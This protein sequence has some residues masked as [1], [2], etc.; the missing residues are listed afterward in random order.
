VYVETWG[1]DTNPGTALAPFA[2][3]QRAINYLAPFEIANIVKIKV[4]PGTFGPFIMSGFKFKSGAQ[5]AQVLVEGTI[6]ST[7]IS[8]TATASLVDSTVLTDATKTWIADEHLGRIV[9]FDLAT[10]LFMPVY[11]NGTN[12]ISLPTNTSSGTYTYEVFNLDTIITGSVNTT[13]GTISTTADAGTGGNAASIGISGTTTGQGIAGQVALKFLSVLNT[14]NSG[15]V[16][17]GNAYFGM[18]SCVVKRT[19]SGTSACLSLANIGSVTMTSCLFWNTVANGPAVI[20][21]TGGALPALL[22]S[23][24]GCYFV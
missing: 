12:T 23:A 15:V 22:V 5:F 17:R 6:T 8:G 13:P 2:T 21:N 18:F 10:Q 7:G 16:A 14:S 19:T 20:M 3:I 11:G 4:G 9:R 24:S 1:N